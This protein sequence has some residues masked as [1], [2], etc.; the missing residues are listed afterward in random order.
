[1]EPSAL[2]VAPLGHELPGHTNRCIRFERAIHPR[3]ASSCAASVTASMPPA[4]VYSEALLCVSVVWKSRL[5]R[6]CAPVRIMEATRLFLEPAMYG[7]TRPTRL[8]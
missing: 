1:V 6:Y 3:S 4:V 5:P 8:G 7:F 2:S